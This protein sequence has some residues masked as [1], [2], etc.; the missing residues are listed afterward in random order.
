M[1]Q[2][3]GPV[4]A[5]LGAARMRRHRST[6]ERSQSRK[7]GGPHQGAVSDGCCN[8][9]HGQYSA[10]LLPLRQLELLLHDNVLDVYAQHGDVHR[11]GCVI[12]LALLLAVSA[13]VTVATVT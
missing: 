8:P 5:A 2:G 7:G 4:L 6:A 1:L 10:L 13:P 3:G 9:A 12:P 11:L